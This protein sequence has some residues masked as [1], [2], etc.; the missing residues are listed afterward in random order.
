MKKIVLLLTALV[1]Y[2][3]LC[4]Q[5]TKIYP[6]N[7]WT[8]MKMNKIQLLVRSDNKLL[9]QQTISINYP[10]VKLLKTHRFPNPKYTAIDIIINPTAKPGTVDIRFGKE[11]IIKWD[12]LARRQGNGTA[13]AQGVTSADFIDLLLTDR[14]SNGDTG[15]DRVAGMR[16]QSLNRDSMY[17]RHGGDFKGIINHIDYFKSLGVTAL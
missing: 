1:S 17:H 7:W 6:T 3:T 5:D 2:S 4:A 9:S 13:Y 11:K 14:F 8:G 16:D 15:N 12:L 10:G